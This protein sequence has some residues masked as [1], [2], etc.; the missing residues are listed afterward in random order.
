M[1]LLSGQSILKQYLPL[2]FGE[3]ATVLIIP[4]DLT[5]GREGNVSDDS[6]LCMVF[7]GCQFFFFFLL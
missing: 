3:S 1:I 5:P 2:L 7:V 6:G 4:K